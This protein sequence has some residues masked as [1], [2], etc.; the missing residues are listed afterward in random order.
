[1]RRN[2][3]SPH[4]DKNGIYRSTKPYGIIIYGL[5]VS[6]TKDC[7]KAISVSYSE[8][9][10]YKT[11]RAQEMAHSALHA[12]HP[13][14]K[15]HLFKND[16]GN[17]KP[18]FPNAEERLKMFSSMYQRFDGSHEKTTGDWSLWFFGVTGRANRKSK[19]KWKKYFSNQ[20][21]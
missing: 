3:F 14:L 2:R 5:Y 10:N 17:C 18:P 21:K 7:V 11:K 13:S 20:S 19:Y 1:M 9:R 4:I 12:N 8:T 6:G 16:N 15:F